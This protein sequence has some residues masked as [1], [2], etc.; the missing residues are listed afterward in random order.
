MTIVTE[1]AT[2]EMEVSWTSTMTSIPSAGHMDNDETGNRLNSIMS[3]AF[4]AA[5]L[6]SWPFMYHNR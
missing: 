3:M 5:L 2:L 6:N 4:G 1:L